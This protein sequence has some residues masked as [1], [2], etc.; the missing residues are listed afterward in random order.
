VKTRQ[1]AVVAGAVLLLAGCG[2]T[3]A[4]PQAERQWIDNASR[5]IDYLEGNVE[6]SAS[7]GANLRTARHA[8]HDDSDLY[9]MV[10]AYSVFGGCEEALLNIGAPSG[11]VRGVER[12]L[13]DACGRFERAA[14]L[15]TRAMKGSNAG[16]LLAATRLALHASPILYRARA[17][18]DAIRE[19][20]S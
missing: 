1:A 13:S 15:F 5:L 4:K 14:S 16:A 9:A 18:L 20:S 12:T 19:A 17:E 7:G 3:R 8:L 2:G 6:L 11:R 10:V